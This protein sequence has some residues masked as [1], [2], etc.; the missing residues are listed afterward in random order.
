MK[1]ASD[2]GQACKAAEIL[3]LARRRQH[4]ELRVR[5]HRILE[6]TGNAAG[7]VKT[8]D[9][10]EALLIQEVRQLG[11]PSMNHWATQAEQRVRD[12]LKGQDGTVR[13]RKK[14]R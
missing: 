5:F 13:S 2:G 7:P 9:E 12:E 11:H 6:R 10:V 14:R 4:P 3:F 1:K 8:A